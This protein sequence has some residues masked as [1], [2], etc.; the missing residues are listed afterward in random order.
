M[1]SS[2]YNYIEIYRIIFESDSQSYLI[3][4]R[5]QQFGEMYTTSIYISKEEYLKVIGKI[6]N[7]QNINLEAITS[8]FACPEFTCI[9]MDFKQLPAPTIIS[10]FDFSP[11]VKQ[12]R[13]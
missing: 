11:A 9:E 6:K 7:T 4:G 13:A 12:I 10:D 5:I 2:Q 3:E 1:S 8:T